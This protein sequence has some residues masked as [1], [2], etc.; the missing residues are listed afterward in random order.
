MEIGSQADAGTSI[1]W[2]GR[3]L[4]FSRSKQKGIVALC[5]GFRTVSGS[6]PESS[7]DF[8]H[9][10]PELLHIERQFGVGSM[11]LSQLPGQASC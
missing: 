11:M 6:P 2:E 10:G 5:T 7:Y 8:L 9:E 4:Y 3:I 1:G